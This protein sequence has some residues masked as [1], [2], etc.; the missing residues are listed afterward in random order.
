MKD[1]HHIHWNNF[2]NNISFAFKEF[3]SKGQFA[4]VTLVSD[5]QTEIQAHKIVLA[6]CSPILKDLLINDPHSYPV[7]YLRGVSKIELQSI[8]EFMY[9][10]EVSIHQDF[11]KKFIT[12]AKDLKIKALMSDN[13]LDLLNNEKEIENVYEFKQDDNQTNETDYIL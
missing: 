7:L 2:H 3:I 10:G 11:I 12:L 1:Q 8:L 6:V 13:I 5:D 9:S 4:D